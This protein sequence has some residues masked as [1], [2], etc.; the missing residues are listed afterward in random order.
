MTQ[1]IVAV[2]NA[3]S[4]QIVALAAVIVG[5]FCIWRAIGVRA[6]ASALDKKI[7]QEQWRF[8]NGIDAVKIERRPQGVDR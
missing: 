6:R 1:S 3:V 7:A 2:M 8:V 4:P 5:G